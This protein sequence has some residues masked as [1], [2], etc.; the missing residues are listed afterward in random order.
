[1]KIGFVIPARLKSTRLP[2][3]IL[4]DFNGKSALEWAI[5]RANKSTYIDEV[6]VATTNLPSDS[7]ITKVCAEN[8]TR[9]FL[10]D[11][12]DVLKRLRDTADYFGFDYIVNITPDNTLF[13]PYLI[14]L[15]VSEIKE[16]PEGDFFRYKDAMLGTGIYAI[17]KEAA[18]IIVEF[19]KVIDTEIWGPLFNERYFN[20]IEMK[21]PEYLKRD[22]RLTLDT[23]EDYKFLTTIY[24][25]LKISE[26]NLVG[27]MDIIQYLDE[28]P[29]V[30]KIN[31][32]VKQTSLDPEII[33][34]I[35]NNFEENEEK[36][37]EIKNRVIK[38]RRYLK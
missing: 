34:N 10:G 3:K 28:N 20:V 25:D 9:Y 5:L 30:V 7:N 11:P 19:K 15:M 22:Y 18:D 1:M 16:N 6:V 38:N 27:L 21:L 33:K 13:S 4:L 14:D 35:N 31:I 36:F 23:P 32:N 37:Y 24:K 8:K 2:K 26:E 12:D 29:E 17:K